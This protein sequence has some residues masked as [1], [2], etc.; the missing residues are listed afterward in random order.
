MKEWSSRLTGVICVVLTW[1]AFLSISAVVSNMEKAISMMGSICLPVLTV[2]A[3]NLYDLKIILALAIIGT[4]YLIIIEF[5]VYRLEIRL[6][7]QLIHISIWLI[8]VI[9]FMIVMVLPLC[10]LLK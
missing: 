7:I 4:I 2:F 10:A 8:L 5:K 3:L 1:L 6:V 9:Y